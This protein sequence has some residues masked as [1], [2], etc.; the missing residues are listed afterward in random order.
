ML[1][2]TRRT[3]NVRTLERTRLLV[4]DTFDLQALMQRNPEIG[5]RIEEIAASRTEFAAQKRH[6]DIIDAELSCSDDPPRDHNE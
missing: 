3:A 4:L 1:R 5:M 6:G 2:R